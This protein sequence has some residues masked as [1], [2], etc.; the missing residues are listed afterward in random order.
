MRS[1]VLL[2]FLVKAALATPFLYVVN[3]TG[4]FDGVYEEKMEPELHYKRLGEADYDGNYKFLYTDSRRPQT[5]ILG[6]GKTLSTA[7][8]KYRAPANGAM[9]GTGAGR[10]WRKAILILISEL[11]EW[12]QISPERSWKSK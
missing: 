6:F 3:G 5:W 1:L 7:R 4:W 8:A 2:L 11:W 9:W 10:G 12:R